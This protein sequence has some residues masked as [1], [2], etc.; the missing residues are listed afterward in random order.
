VQYARQLPLNAAASPLTR[1]KSDDLTLREREVAAL[2]AQGKSN[3][4]IADALVVSKRTVETHIAH[5]LAKLGFTN[6]AQV[7][8]WAIEVGLTQPA[9]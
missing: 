1:K 7:V 2:V 9:K 6:R 3:G 5:I 8:R 4:E